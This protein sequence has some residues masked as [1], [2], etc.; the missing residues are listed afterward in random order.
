VAFAFVIFPVFG[1]HPPF[2]KAPPARH[3]AL[4]ASLAKGQ[5]KKGNP[6]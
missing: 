2:T 1:I 6:T 5:S 4:L 3:F